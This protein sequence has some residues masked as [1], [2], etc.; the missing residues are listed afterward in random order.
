MLQNNIY[1]N[2]IIDIN[3]IFYYILNNKK[4]LKN[5]TKPNIYII[6]GI[7]RP[8]KLTKIALIYNIRYTF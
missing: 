2:K 8:L 7:A 4:K 1:N 5:E 3:L 6:C